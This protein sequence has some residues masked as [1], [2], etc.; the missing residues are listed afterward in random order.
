MTNGTLTGAAGDRSEDQAA[1]TDLALC[2][3]SDAHGE[4][5]AGVGSYVGLGYRHRAPSPCSVA[6]CDARRLLTSSPWI[7]TRSSGGSA[8]T[9]VMTRLW[10]PCREGGCRVRG[11]RFQ[12]LG[13]RSC[14]TRSLGL[15]QLATYVPRMG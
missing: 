3:S 6:T 2:G 9:A 1:A 4:D 13:S 15:A 7:T 11:L 8:A 10:N 12:V 5:P 14:H